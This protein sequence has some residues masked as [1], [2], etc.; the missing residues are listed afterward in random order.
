[1]IDDNDYR[2]GFIQGFFA[3][4]G[5]AAALAAA[6]PRGVDQQGDTWKK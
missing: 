6:L 1:M 4:R 5:S 3:I 2:E